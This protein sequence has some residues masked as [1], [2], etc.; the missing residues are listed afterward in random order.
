MNKV[1]KVIMMSVALV[2][3]FA[4]CSLSV[5]ATYELD[6]PFDSSQFSFQRTTSYVYSND[7]PYGYADFTSSWA[8]NKLKIDIGPNSSWTA[9]SRPDDG[10]YLRFRYL[11]SADP[12]RYWK[13]G[14]SVYLILDIYTQAYGV[15][16]TLPKL[17]ISDSSSK[18]Y[19]RLN[20]EL[21]N[22]GN[23]GQGNYYYRIEFRASSPL[24]YDLSL[25]GSYWTFDLRGISGLENMPGLVTSQISYYYSFSQLQVKSFANPDD[26]RTAEILGSIDDLEQSITEGWTTDSNVNSTVSDK[27]DQMGDAESDALGGKSDQEIQQEIQGVLSGDGLPSVNG[28][29]VV[30]VANTFDLLLDAFG[31]DYQALLILALTL[32]LAAVLVGRSFRARGD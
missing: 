6:I 23:Y 24:D 7:R 5:F 21:I 9:D 27:S 1:I 30:A 31:K 17:I 2:C 28:G 3:V 25:G 13:R 18:V 4:L 12:V 16:T 19:L 14:E 15:L 32:G 29:G 22:E 26:E 10:C 20:G 8:S 11:E